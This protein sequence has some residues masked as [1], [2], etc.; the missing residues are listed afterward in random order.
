MK[1]PVLCKG[2]AIRESVY[3]ESDKCMTYLTDELGC[4]TVFCKGARAYKSK[5]FAGTQLF[6][7][8]ELELYE[9]GDRY[10]LKEC[11]YIDNFYHIRDDV[12]ACALAQYF[13][14]VV[15]DVTRENQKEPGV[16]QLLLNALYILS[17]GSKSLTLVKGVF[18]LRLCALSGFLPDLTGCA[19][20]GADGGDMLFD[21][22][23]GQLYC[24]S[25][26]G[27]TDTTVKVGGDVLT[28]MRYAVAAPAQRIFAFELPED[29]LASFG[30][31]SERYLLNQMD[32]S[33]RTLEFYKTIE[34]I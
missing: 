26:K 1:T 30:R 15:A 18:E 33:Y 25:H 34:K 4:I 9:R 8:S 31:I 14:D 17:K 23:G 12:C 19:V 3:G 22:V 21:L 2:V 6:C 11:A 13:C 16:L 29:I 5:F 28:A 27:G 20:C 24:T 7:Y 10:W 32:R